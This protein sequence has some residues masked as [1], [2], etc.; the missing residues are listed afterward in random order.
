MEWIDFRLD[1]LKKK[2]S[3]ELSKIQSRIH[4][5]EAYIIV[6]KNL[7]EILKIIRNEDNPKIK[8]KDCSKILTLTV[9]TFQKVSFSHFIEQK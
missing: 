6:Y 3:W 1:T 5:L 4:I 9:I 8:L 7:D 2:F